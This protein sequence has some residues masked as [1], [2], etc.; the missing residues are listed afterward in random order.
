MNR[1]DTVDGYRKKRSTHPTNTTNATPGLPFSMETPERV[2]AF[3]LQTPR[4]Y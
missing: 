4:Q 3:L 1:F 2:R